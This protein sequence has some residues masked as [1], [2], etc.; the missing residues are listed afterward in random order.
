MC[1]QPW[2]R[3]AVRPRPCAGKP[4][5]GPQSSAPHFSVCEVWE[6]NH[7]TRWVS[8]RGAGV[9]SPVRARTLQG[10]ITRL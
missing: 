3:Q 2:T 6:Q 8:E 7:S 9:G 4:S 5:P 1:T 10:F